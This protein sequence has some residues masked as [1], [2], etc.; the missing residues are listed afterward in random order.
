M[1]RKIWLFALVAVALAAVTAGCGGQQSDLVAV[2]GDH[3]I[4]RTEFETGFASRPQTFTSYD[5]EIEGRRNF[6]ADMI[7]Q[8]L[9]VIGA[10]KQ[11]LDESSEIQRL[12]E[13]Q[14]GKF[15]L[16]QLYKQK[17]A[18]QVEVSEADV[19]KWYENMGEEI[20]ARHILLANLEDAQAV[21][22]ELDGGADFTTMAKERSQD[23]SAAQNAGDLSWFRWGTMVPAF[24]EAAF[25]LSEN[26]ISEPVQ[27]DFGF[28]VIQLLGRRQVDR[29]P[30]DQAKPSI[31][32]TIRQQKTQ[33]R[34]REF[35][36]TVKDKAEL[37][38]DMDMLTIIQETYRDTTGP[39]EFQSNL[40]PNV[41]NPKLQVRPLVRY[42]DTA[43]LSGD[44]IRQANSVPPVNRPSFYDTTATKEFIFQM[45]YTQILEREARRLRIDLSEDYQIQLRQFREQLMAD[46][47]R[48]DLLQRPVDVTTEMLRAYYD[49]HPEEFSTPPQVRVR[50][51][52]VDTQDEADKI[53]ER[54]RRGTKF[55]DICSKETKRP[56]M[57]ARQGDLGNFRRF[58]HPNLFDAAQRMEIGQVGG[59]IF[60]AIQTGAQ[61]SVIE[62]IHRADAEIKTYEE[63]ED[64]MLNKIRNEMRQ[65][66]L[67]G[68]LAET[69]NDTKVQVNEEALA[70]T[71]DL[72]KYPEKG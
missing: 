56:G 72:T 48:N 38:L 70:A 59:P 44:F 32:Q 4:S 9:M 29:Q 10:Y 39:L 26:E 67:E 18:N 45:I 55:A 5:A 60:H 34:L 20:H 12:I 47:M 37:R 61:W 52:L 27:T 30:F 13:Q 58:E 36:V 33:T 41:L 7:D 54:V 31:E 64:R 71:I 69:R 6:L 11:G 3:T 62:L 40:D 25:N 43:L 24:Q 8:K 21:R 68:W 35:L 51:A 22:T 1:N 15:L 16:D 17:I 53:I 65:E 57:R 63:V 46:K 66:A 28:H 2:V 14:Q 19:Q 50:E 49:E 23:P 42:L